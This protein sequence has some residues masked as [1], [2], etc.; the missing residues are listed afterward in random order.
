MADDEVAGSGSGNVAA[1]GRELDLPAVEGFGALREIGVG[2]FSRVFEAL[3]FEF[4]RWVA[5][6]VLNDRL[7][8]D[9]G[10]A[11]FERECRLLGV[12]SRHPNVVTVFASAFAADGH[13]AIVMEL[14]RAGSYMDVVRGSGPL[15]VREL[16]AAGVAVSGALGTAHVQGVVHGDVKPHNVFRSEF[17]SAVL[18][19]FGIASL[20]HLGSAAVRTRL[21]LYYAAPELVEIGASASSPFA[22]QYSLA[23]TMYALG[24]GS[25]PFDGGVDDTT[26]RLLERMVYEPAPRLESGF[27][28]SLADV[29]AKAMAREPQDRFGDMADFAAALGGVER[30][31]GLDPTSL[32]MSSGESRYVGRTPGSHSLTP[33]TP[34]DSDTSPKP[35]AAAAP[36]A[37]PE[38]SDDDPTEQSQTVMRPITPS[39]LPASEPDHSPAEAKR[40]PRWAKT[41]A[42]AMAAIAVAIAVLVAILSASDNAVDDGSIT[43]GC[44]DDGLTLVV[45]NESKPLDVGAAVSLVAA[46]Q[47]DA[48]LFVTEDSLTP[49]AIAVVTDFPPARVFLVGGVAALT[50]DIRDVLESLAP[51]DACIERIGGGNH[52]VTAGQV[53]H[54]VLGDSTGGT[55][56]VAYDES[57]ADVGVAASLVASGGADALLF[58]SEHDD[59][60]DVTAVAIGQR[61]PERV[62]LVGSTAALSSEIE[63]QLKQVTPNVDVDR[64]DGNT[65]FHTA[66]LAAEC[67]FTKGATTAVIANGWKPEDVGVAAAYAAVRGGTAVLYA[68]PDALAVDTDDNDTEE[69][70]REF[71]PIQVVL[72]GGTDH[73]SQDVYAEVRDVVP[74]AEVHRVRG[75][76]TLEIAAKATRLALDD[77]KMSLT[78]GNGAESESEPC[79]P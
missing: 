21:S 8:G 24:T 64:F 38:D 42:A 26:E 22:D 79:D 71:E 2:G 30:E 48:M 60:G 66:A 41:A 43:G 67:A 25:R 70:L 46:D 77:K 58:A 28:E 34:R 36:M 62:L 56:V 39:R 49:A 14:F 37:A 59:L 4:R 52:V 33:V 9:D 53:V 11:D 16:L 15:G 57:L 74:D 20:M 12:L 65:R 29:L 68:G 5:I 75:A 55:L 27:P 72:I 54:R 31:Q 44:A 3:E 17:G 45:A 78:S 73:L 47:G 61:Y 69:K 23:A 32:L 18:G 19:D 13:P 10:V 1:V 63:T 51:D 7:E 6:K 40:I 76:T 50:E 35:A